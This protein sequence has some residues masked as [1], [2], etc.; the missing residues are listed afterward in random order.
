MVKAVT[1]T[2][3]AEAKSEGRARNTAVWKAVTCAAAAM[4]FSLLNC[5]HVNSQIVN[6][7]PYVTFM[8]LSVGIQPFPPCTPYVYTW[9]I[10]IHLQ[11]S[12]LNAGATNFR[13]R[14]D[15]GDGAVQE[16]PR[17][18]FTQ[19]GTS[20]TFTIFTATVTHTYTARANCGYTIQNEFLLGSNTTWC[21]SHLR[22]PVE[23]WARDNVAASGGELR[24][25]SEV[26]NSPGRP[27][28]RLYCEGSSIDAT[29]FDVTRMACVVST[30]H[31][32]NL[33]MRETRYRYGTTNTIGGNIG[34]APGVS[35]APTI[36][37]TATT[38]NPTGT[39][40]PNVGQIPAMP[41]VR[42]VRD[43]DPPTV[44]G[45]VYVITLDN[46]NVCN[47][48]AAQNPN[49][50]VSTIAQVRII[51]RPPRPTPQT[52]EFCHDNHYSGSASMSANVSSTAIHNP[53]G[54]TGGF[55]TWYAA[56]AN[57]E[58]TGNPIF[59]GATFNPLNRLT[60]GRTAGQEMTV[61]RPGIYDFWVVYTA[62]TNE[63][64]CTSEPS[65]MRWVIRNDI[66]AVPVKGTADRHTDALHNISIQGAAPTNANIRQGYEQGAWPTHVCAGERFTLRLNPHATQDAN[67]Q[68]ITSGG[69][70]PYATIDQNVHYVWAIITGTSHGTY[71]GSDHNAKFVHPNG[72]RSGSITTATPNAHQVDIVFGVEGNNAFGKFN[73]LAPQTVTIRVYRRYNNGIAT[74]T[75][76]GV[77]R[78]GCRWNPSV[79]TWHNV[80]NICTAC[81]GEFFD[82][83]VVVHPRP[84]ASLIEQESSRE[85]CANT[86]HNLQIRRV[87]GSAV[88]NPIQVWL[89]NTSG[90]IDP[91]HTITVNSAGAAGNFGDNGGTGTINVNPPNGS[92]THYT[93]Q[94]ARDNVTGC[95]SERTV[96]HIHNV[97]VAHEWTMGTC[98]NTYGSCWCCIS[99]YARIK[100]TYTIYKRWPLAT[101]TWLRQPPNLLC[102]S[103]AYNQTGA[104]DPRRNWQA[105]IVFGAN[106]SPT[107]LAGPQMATGTNPVT[108]HAN[109][110]VSFP[111]ATAVTRNL[112]HVFSSTGAFSGNV[113]NS[114]VFAGTALSRTTTNGAIPNGTA[115]SVSVRTIYQDSGIR[116]G[117]NS[118]FA[119]STITSSHTV[120]PHPT[121][122]VGTQVQVALNG[123]MVN[124]SNNR[125][126]CNDNTTGIRFLIQAT[127]FA[128]CNWS[129]GWEL[130]KASYGNALILSGVANI[131]GTT[132][133]TSAHFPI[134]FTPQQLDAIQ[135]TRPGEYILLLTWVRQNGCGTG[136]DCPDGTVNNNPAGTN[137]NRIN[138]RP[139]ISASISGTQQICEG[140][141][142]PNVRVEFSPNDAG[143]TYSFTYT[144]SRPGAGNVT[145]SNITPPTRFFDVAPNLINTGSGTTTV[146]LVSVSQTLNGLTCPASP[147]PQQLTGQHVITTVRPK[148]AGDDVSGCSNTIQLAAEPAE[149]GETG[150]WQ[151]ET[152]PNTFVNFSATNSGNAIRD[153][154]LTGGINNP[155]AVIH[156]AQGE[157]GTRRLRWQISTP[158]GT[159][160]CADEVYVSFGTH[161]D[162]GEIRGI[163]STCGLEVNLEGRSTGLR[164]LSSPPHE[165]PLEVNNTGR[166]RRWEEGV[167]VFMGYT[168]PS[169]PV[170]P[171]G[172]GS[173]VSLRN[174]DTNAATEPLNQTVPA[175]QPNNYPPSLAGRPILSRV[176]S[177]DNHNIGFIVDRPGI[178]E[179][180]FFIRTGCS[181]P[182]LRTHKVEFI[183][184]PV[185]AAVP[186][187]TLCPAETENITF[188]DANWLSS[189]TATTT[190][191]ITYTWSGPSHPSSISNAN[192]PAVITASANVTT[193]PI[194][195][196]F[197]V[198]P[199]FNGCPGAARNFNVIVKPK[200]VLFA[201]P[202]EHF[203]CPGEEFS[204]WL[205]NRPMN[206]NS[207]VQ[208]ATYTWE[209]ESSPLNPTSHD[210]QGFE[211]NTSGVTRPVDAT[212]NLVFTSVEPDNP[213]PDT[214]TITVTAEVN[215]CKSEP[216]TYQ[217]TVNPTPFLHFQ[218]GGDNVTV[219]DGISHISYCSDQNVTIRDGGSEAPNLHLE[220]WSNVQGADYF[221]NVT[222]DDVGDLMPMFVELPA[223]KVNN[224]SPDRFAIT[225]DE[226]FRTVDNTTIN[227]RVASV[228]VRAVAGGCSAT[229]SYIMIVKP[230]PVIMSLSDQALCSSTAPSHL[231]T[232]AN[233]NPQLTNPKSSHEFTYSWVLPLPGEIDKF[234]PSVI[235][236]GFPGVAG[237]PMTNPAP[238]AEV[239]LI[240]GDESKT[241]TVAGGTP[242]AG[243]Q[244][245]VGVD[246]TNKSVQIRVVPR[247]EGCDGTPVNFSLTSLLRP[248][249]LP[250]GAAFTAEH[251]QAV[252]SGNP[253]ADLMFRDNTGG[254]LVEFIWTSDNQDTGVA[255]NSP[256]DNTGPV[257]A[258]G[259]EASTNISGVDIV[260]TVTVIARTVVVGPG[261]TGCESTPETFTYTV[262]PAPVIDPVV[263]SIDDA[264]LL[265]IGGVYEFCKDDELI[266]APFTSANIAN[267]KN[268]GVKY[269]WGV[270]NVLVGVDLPPISNTE[271]FLPDGIT[272][273]PNYYPLDAIKMRDFVGAN[274]ITGDKIPSTVTV[275]A[276]T[277]APDNCPQVMP[278]DIQLALKP[279]AQMSPVTPDPMYYCTGIQTQVVPF[280]N[281]ISYSN[282]MLDTRWTIDNPSISRAHTTFGGATIPA[283]PAA[284]TI[285]T[286]Y[287]PAFY[288]NNPNSE[289]KHDDPPVEAEVTA[290]SVVDG[291][292]GDPITFRIV[293]RPLPDINIPADT[294]MCVGEPFPPVFLSSPS[295]PLGTVPVTFH[296]RQEGPSIGSTMRENT[297]F[298]RPFNVDN[299][300]PNKLLPETSTFVAWAVFDECTSP[301]ARFTV[302]VLPQAQMRDYGSIELCAGDPESPLPFVSILPTQS[303]DYDLN[304]SFNW[305]FVNP[306]NSNDELYDPPEEWKTIENSWIKPDDP[307]WGPGPALG[308][309][310]TTIA[311]FTGRQNDYG[312]HP[313][314]VHDDFP[315]VGHLPWF[316][317]DTANIPHPSRLW[318][319]TQIEQLRITPQVSMRLPAPN[320]NQIKTC[321]GI[322]TESLITIKPLPI[323]RFSPNMDPCVSQ[324]GRSL[325]ELELVNPAFLASGY[326]WG[327]YTAP[328]A[329]HTHEFGPD[330]PNQRE[331]NAITPVGS[332]K[333]RSYE[334]F[335]Y[336]NI[337]FW[338]GYIT[339][340]QEYEGCYA[341]VL[342]RRIRTE[343]APVV[344]FS[345]SPTELDTLIHVCHG[346]VRQVF[347]TVDGKTELDSHINIMYISEASLS[348]RIILNPW[349]TY[350]HSPN[351]P[352]ATI[353]FQAQGGTCKSEVLTLQAVVYPL[354]EAI[355]MPDREYCSEQLEWN[356]SVAHGSV[357]P[358]GSII[359]ENNTP[360]YY[361]NDIA[362][363]RIIN[364]NEIALG[365]VPS[366]ALQV[367]MNA[368]NSTGDELAHANSLPMLP[369]E[370]TVDQTFRYSVRQTRT[371]TLEDG[372]TQFCRSS[373]S[374]ANMLV[375]LSPAAPTLDRLAA[376][377]GAM[378][379]CHNPSRPYTL[380][381][382]GDAFT[383][384]LNWFEY[385][386]D[387]PL[388]GNI[389]LVRINST[390]ANNREASISVWQQEASSVRTAETPSSPAEFE[391]FTYYVQATGFNRC[392][393]A[394]VEVP[395]TIFPLPELDILL[396]KKLTT[397]AFVEQEG[398]CSPFDQ[399][400]SNL[401]PSAFVD[402]RLRWNTTLPTQLIQRF[403]PN[404]PESTR[405][406]HEFD[407]RG[408]MPE[409]ATIRLE[410]IYS[411]GLYNQDTRFKDPDVGGMIGAYCRNVLERTI[412][413]QPGVRAQFITNVSEG[414]GPLN[415]MIT[416]QGQSF[417]AINF[418][419]YL[420]WNSTEFSE[421]P[422]PG[423]DDPALDRNFTIAPSDNPNNMYY[424]ASVPNMMHSFPHTSGEFAPQVYNVWLQVDNGACY[425]NVMRQIT[426]YP[427]PNADFIHT[428]SNIATEQVCPPDGV[429]FTNTSASNPL[430]GQ[431]NSGD[432]AANPTRYFWTFGDGEERITLDKTPF[433][434]EYTNR[435]SSSRISRP[436]LMTARNEFTANNGAIITCS[437]PLARSTVMVAPQVK[438]AFIGDREACSP[439]TVRFMNMSEG[440]INNFAWNFGDGTT[441][442]IPNPTYVTEHTGAR[443][444]ARH[445]TVSLTVSNTWCSDT[446]SQPFSL[447]PQPVASFILPGGG[448]QPLEAVFINTSIDATL[449]GGRPNPL[450]GVTYTY[451][452]GDGESIT[453]DN[454]SPVSHTYVNELGAILPRYPVL[455]AT[456]QWG[457]TAQTPTGIGINAINILPYIKA[458]FIMEP[459]STPHCSPLTVYFRNTSIG[460]THFEYD[461]DDG[462]VISYDKLSGG[463]ISRVFSTDPSTGM[464]QDKNFN[465]TLT[466]RNDANHC[467]DTH[468]E[469]LTVLATPV[470]NFVPGYPYPLDFQWPTP[471]I[472]IT[473]LIPANQRGQLTYEWSW[474]NT[475]LRQKNVF[476]ESVLPNNLS[477]SQWG[478]FDIT[479][480]VTAPNGLC[481]DT[482]TL[483]VKIVAPVVFANFAD[484]PPQCAP[485]EVRFDN[486]SRW[487]ASS[488]WNFGDGYTSTETNPVHV[489]ADPGVYTVTLIVTSHEGDRSTM[490]K[491]VVVHPTPKPHFQVSPAHLFV[492]QEMRAFNFTQHTMPDGVTQ[493]PVWYQWDWGDGSPHDTARVTTHTFL[494]AGSFDVTLT[495][496]TYTQPQCV[497][498]YT[499]Y[500]AIELESHG[501]IR[502]PNVFR[503]WTPETQGIMGGGSET[504]GDNGEVPGSGVDIGDVNDPN[505][506]HGVNDIGG[507]QGNSLIRFPNNAQYP[508]DHTDPTDPN[509]PNHPL[510][511]N[512]PFSPNYIPPAITG[513]QPDN[514]IPS[515]GYKNHLFF[516]S[517]LSP[518]SSYRMTI[519]SRW[520]V[521]IFETND[522][523][524]GWNGYY[525]DRLC[526]EGVYIYKIEGVFQTG[527]P[528]SVSGDITLLR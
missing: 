310:Y 399:Y 381:A 136:L 34:P 342:R 344:T 332:F 493:Y 116:P 129:V 470:A 48:P 17:N 58:M 481:Y 380:Y 244:V 436:I 176:N 91:S 250:E 248:K 253:F 443:D 243:I 153:V 138:V 264:T 407:T 131:P 410:G 37:S 117:G 81:P 15:W 80:G 376:D 149:A 118:E 121:A 420:N 503:P 404:N 63:G 126:I 421:P 521:K 271:E 181:P 210:N 465:I 428:Y 339:V 66:S 296:W 148:S 393:S 459:V 254:E 161:P 54:F 14:V 388:S 460:D 31:N 488:L 245:P 4:F 255:A 103:T 151:I 226:R 235:Q 76:G 387:P 142:A 104:S 256:A 316:V 496:G 409:A 480:H 482:Q 200:P 346:E 102:P 233:I 416:G 375:M 501:D 441:D 159:P 223:T 67:P 49:G 284:G 379:Y 360:R 490:T 295:F 238:P 183:A 445:Q 120:L 469:T 516:P 230:R 214:G 411:S 423:H 299:G 219:V 56:G 249:I 79:T 50:Q 114:A 505:N 227:D 266:F 320:E 265:A 64:T 294:I 242:W 203:L 305:R 5:Q 262:L 152:S 491:E 269:S 211:P 338:E 101:P 36:N 190:P 434:H 492:G 144:T 192:N 111:A 336:Q 527:R 251:S 403:D 335:H 485:T 525:R 225:T 458:D 112:Q 123:Q 528:F 466:A 132:S 108:L 78:P 476:S 513:V 272:P 484:V 429:L 426:V 165:H 22:E 140:Q 198:T 370:M 189:F 306:A 220:F 519:F 119:T 147:L 438:A 141:T 292:A 419:Y 259:F 330:I 319:V 257:H 193:S 273:N 2:N 526:E 479:Q 154:W 402:Y 368:L 100:N 462:S 146:T 261:A 315:V 97:E 96:S 367:T 318:T 507:F 449:H 239:I 431:I 130:R 10:V 207:V 187:I 468:T 302:T 44:A 347:A 314:G 216:V 455:I 414:C 386:E 439:A 483:A 288:T 21:Q 202:G 185:V 497:A 475:D 24:L 430:L 160:P 46:W 180:A 396:E 373:A 35:Q 61:S 425:D 366:K 418:R 27:W 524:K 204:V 323:T 145:I 358:D 327:Y 355:S 313:Q 511:P 124:V 446:Y 182:L 433:Y 158:Q 86:S 283:L 26:Q 494:R 293:I 99:S 442:N 232:F 95:V 337:G 25:H 363:H 252:C 246:A 168:P 11:T 514:S 12:F 413:I 461:F 62:T 304:Y 351:K 477:L 213:F 188:S 137:W 282:E 179:F 390:P 3:M 321:N 178:Y 450:N 352:V 341:P 474:V 173:V 374:M 287:F 260:S 39:V 29:F 45:Q 222:G 263:I 506:P 41:I 456:N 473:N 291:C 133:G 495:V 400:L 405:Y 125:I 392:L 275:F 240:G 85:L 143:S 349:A 427:V 69:T 236:D 231:F 356:M 340:Q 372:N 212:T 19:A 353:S 391:P 115:A 504:N 94:R 241:M 417:R 279:N 415:V 170:S 234:D 520:G 93:I 285:N 53:V 166:V 9:N 512:N 467:T 75:N 384:A 297:T 345:F 237:S 218:T 331:P 224:D 453:L 517:V 440:S 206:I 172:T 389:E 510:S 89:A 194:T 186:D 500:G 371:Y 452:F 298:I 435:I 451:I 401:S 448:C 281:D 155:N 84:S 276:V 164:L 57:G 33:N 40:P 113:T 278:L 201:R 303:H 408:T 364:G 247:M 354:P 326:E 502:L 268:I 195:H 52:W 7:Q 70:S 471:P 463:F 60:G 18:Q 464:W 77:S 290:W 184:V 378:S 139:S 394:L 522:P 300:T 357:G 68:R 382:N 65:R 73:T 199:S 362:W 489:Y 157:F 110:T 82:H 28:E 312:G 311:H 487:A 109:N 309:P 334:V 498:S 209:S 51:A 509:H 87:R 38:S 71:C 205:S 106:T 228:A 267:G 432:N 270:S 92:V 377:P 127:G 472:T 98:C 258:L 308:N 42:V 329:M 422:Y 383:N 229:G 350:T 134:E 167:W 286:G 43:A 385:R 215:G 72:T 412:M 324:G 30:L 523:T 171:A 333:G 221:F 328:D 361:T 197:T 454:S 156:I 369:R 1:Y 191:M 444:Q 301:E 177:D 128:G 150:T 277:D 107:N 174:L 32:P 16:I 74:N 424:G 162:D 88:G 8:D 105:S 447:N 317:G 343:P 280:E 515:R 135:A 83:H 208:Q 217:I 6:C 196:S 274:N 359:A 322:P 397:G 478:T 47:G 437:S 457:C 325:Y 406:M 13:M 499:M 59:T 518:T 289:P 508:Y 169:Y 20:G 175:G 486:L 398:G 163:A 122:R 395:L 23:A 90:T 348:S 55:Y 365:N 307:L